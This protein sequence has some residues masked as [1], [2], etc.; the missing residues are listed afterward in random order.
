MTS[1]ENY[2]KI[3]RELR[4]IRDEVYELKEGQGRIFKNQTDIEN[5][6]D[7]LINDNQ[8]ELEKI[9]EISE[10]RETEVIV[11][12]GEVTPFHKKILDNLVKK[13][14][15]DRW[16]TNQHKK[17]INFLFGD[18]KYNYQNKK[19]I[20]A[21]FSEIR[22]SCHINNSAM[23]DLLVKL[24]EENYIIAKIMSEVDPSRKLYLANLNFFKN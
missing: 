18:S 13:M 4:K 23:K 5:K 8:K 16:L 7:E 2:K 19:F 9:K 17:I 1:D 3:L 24:L 20:G 6:I 22:K 14:E 11:N 21:N 15:S 12:F 10:I